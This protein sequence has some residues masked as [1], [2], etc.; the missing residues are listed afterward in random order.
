MKPLS[1]SELRYRVTLRRMEMRRGPLGEP[2]PVESVDVATLWT[3]VEP[4][5]NR[6]IRNIDQ[7]QVVET[8]QFTLRPRSDVTQDWQVV[9]GRQ[10]F[11]VRSTDRT[12]ADRLIIT[13]EA[14]IRHDRTGD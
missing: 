9:L 8:Y 1:A 2:L 3:K 4:I 5:S 7:Q 11:T 12:Q 10:F 13:A 14:D 6:K